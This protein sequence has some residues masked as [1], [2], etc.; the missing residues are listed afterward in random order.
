MPMTVRTERTRPCS[1]TADRGYTLRVP[2]Y[3][4]QYRRYVVPEV[5]YA[6]VLYDTVRYGTA[7][8]HSDMLEEPQVD[9]GSQEQPVWH[10]LVDPRT[11]S[12]CE[13]RLH[14]ILLSRPDHT[15]RTEPNGYILYIKV[16]RVRSLTG[17]RYTVYRRLRYTGG[18]AE[19]YL[20]LCGW[21]CRWSREP[22]L[23]HRLSQ[24]GRGQL[25]A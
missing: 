20:S 1:S 6:A 22:S 21:T 7:C 23:D 15:R 11:D 16:Y 2:L 19:V 24:P 5:R 3:I 25:Q 9:K 13:R 12:T 17:T 8:P 18:L 4:T 10:R 14:L